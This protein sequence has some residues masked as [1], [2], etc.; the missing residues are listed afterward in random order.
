[1]TA[2]RLQSVTLPAKGL[3]RGDYRI[4]VVFSGSDGRRTTATARA[5]RL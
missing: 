2:G 5:F 1:M 3:A 4:N